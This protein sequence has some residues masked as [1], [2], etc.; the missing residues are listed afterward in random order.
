V[1]SWGWGW[2]IKTIFL[3]KNYQDLLRVGI[4]YF[5]FEEYAACGRCPSIFY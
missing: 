3:N 2:L 5:V 1:G 4:S